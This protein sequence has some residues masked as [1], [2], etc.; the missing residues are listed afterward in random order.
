MDSLLATYASSDEDADE[1]IPSPA[2]ATRRGEASGKPAGGIFSALPQPKSAPIFSSLPAPKSAATFSS[3]PPPKSSVSSGNP[4]R[5]V[6]FRPPPIRQTTGVSS[7]EDDDAEKRRP[8]VSEAPP[9]LSAGSG[10]V[11]SFLPAPRHSLGF[12][13]G[14]ARRSAVDTAGPER[15]NLGAAGPSSS[16]VNR[17]APERSDTGP[18][19]EDDPEKSSDED[20]M[21]A[22][23]QQQ[24]QQGLG[25]EAGDVQHQGCDAGVGNANGYEGYAWDPNYYAYYGLD[26]NSN[27]NYGAE[28]QYAAYGVEQGGGY[29]N[30]YGGEHSGGYEHSTAPPCGGEYTGGY[31]AE[32]VAMAA[33]PMRE[34]ALPPELGRIGVKR[35]RRDMPMEIIEVN[36]AELVKNRPREDKSKLTG[37]AFGP[38]YQAAPSGK[39]KP[40]KLQKRK[41]QIGSLFYDLKQKEMELS[42]R[43]AKGFLTKAETQAKYGW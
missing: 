33:P 12:G 5:V 10:P 19:D 21:P 1:S 6:Q 42:E 20:G 23:E 31:S 36:Q 8:S 32:A 41:H 29:D 17:G 26:P 9:P 16:A 37:M 15:S 7:D 38:S 25:A 39:G 34:P 24:E 11:S 14:A 2:P 27:L 35:G 3:I 40:S 30:G 28:P 4:K 18:A 22:P 43:R 13:S